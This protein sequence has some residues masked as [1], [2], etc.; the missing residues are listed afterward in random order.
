MLKTFG[1][2]V[3][4]RK[5]YNNSVLY[6]FLPSCKINYTSPKLLNYKVLVSIEFWKKKQN[7]IINK[8][9]LKRFKETARHK[10]CMWLEPV[11]WNEKK[12]YSFFTACSRGFA[13]KVFVNW[14]QKSKLRVCFF[15]NHFFFQNFIRKVFGACSFACVS[16][17]CFH[18][19]CFA[20]TYMVRETETNCLCLLCSFIDGQ[21]N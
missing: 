8:V 7:L 14:L 21:E 15:H 20:C 17:L 5:F 19:S 18:L 3:Q 11:T 10:N 13:N 16:V 4:W 12:S 2:P 1:L 9:W 6:V